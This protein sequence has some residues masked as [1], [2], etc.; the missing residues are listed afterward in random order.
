[1]LLSGDGQLDQAEDTLREALEIQEALLEREPSIP[2]HRWQL[3]RTSNNLGV[4]LLAKRRLPDAEVAARKALKL[5][6]ALSVEY[7][8]V[9]AYAQ[10]LVA[11][12][13]NLGLILQE[14]VPE[15]AE[16]EYRKALKRLE[17]LAARWPNMP[18]MLYRTALTYLNLAVLLAKGDPAEAERTYHQALEIQDRLVARFPDVPEYECALGRTLHDLSFLLCSRTD[19]RGARRLLDQAIRHLRAALEANPQIASYHKYLGDS[20]GLFAKTLVQLGEHGEAADAAEEVPGVQPEALE[21]RLRAAALLTQCAGLA[22][23]DRRLADAKRRDLESK[24]AYRAVKLLRNAVH[25]GLLKDVR[26]LDLPDFAPLRERDDFK[27]L[28]QLL[29]D[30]GKIRLG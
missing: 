18:D 27:A 4:L 5:Q 13:A 11:A 23:A 10:E 19:F 20:L 9:P 7:P 6:E 25:Q 14:R 29:E 21:Q 1:M 24:Y 22:A 2:G 16:Q 30:G 26:V 12:Q 17:S 28:R 8:N 15:E 3:A